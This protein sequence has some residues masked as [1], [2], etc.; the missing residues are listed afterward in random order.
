MNCDDDND[1]DDDCNRLI[2]SALV[3]VCI[4]KSK[5]DVLLPKDGNKLLGH[6]NHINELQPRRDR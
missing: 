3:R 5:R 6:D 2:V 1:D 4:L